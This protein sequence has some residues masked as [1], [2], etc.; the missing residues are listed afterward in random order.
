MHVRRGRAPTIEAD[1]EETAAV[2]AR[3]ER[4]REPALRVWRPHRQVAFGRR[5]TSVDGY[6]LARE[7]AEERGFP[8]TTRDV[9]GRAVAFTG[10]TVAFA[11]A[12]PVDGPRGGIRQRYDDALATLQRA[13]ASVDVAAERGEPPDSFCPGSHSL[14]AGGKLAGLAQRVTDDAAVVA[15]V[16]VVDERDQFTSVIGAVYDRLGVPFDPNSVGSVAD[17]GGRA[18][19]ERVADAVAASFAADQQPGVR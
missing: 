2:V 11:R 16:L 1:R 19:P 8:A 4:D 6:E 7:A 14:Q 9:G 12:V 10:S 15:G 3:A 13:L 18:D 5:D 17:A